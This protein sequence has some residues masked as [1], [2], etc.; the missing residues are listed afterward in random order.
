[1]LYLVVVHDV[2]T[3]DDDVVCLTVQQVFVKTSALCEDVAQ[4]H[5]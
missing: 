3:S 5:R 1:M 2:G 4:D